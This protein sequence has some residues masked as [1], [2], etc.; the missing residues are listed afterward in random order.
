MVIYYS[1]LHLLT[2]LLLCTEG[3]LEL[4]CYA[5]VHGDRIN[6]RTVQ[7]F[8]TANQPAVF[9]CGINN[10]PLI[11]CKNNLFLQSIVYLTDITGE[12]PHNF[13]NIGISDSIPVTVIADT[14]VK[15]TPQSLTCT[16]QGMEM[17]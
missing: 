12:S 8:F 15:E 7:V 11:D 10:G 13:T 17:Q 5:I 2:Y 4:E 9:R 16:T 14:T 1:K 6:G 3:D